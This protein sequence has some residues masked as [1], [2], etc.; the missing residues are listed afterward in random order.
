M[1]LETSPGDSA[2]LLKF[3]KIMFAF[4]AIMFLLV[5]IN[6]GAK[7]KAEVASP[8]S[9]I[10][11]TNGVATVSKDFRTPF[12]GLSVTSELLKK[13]YEVASADGS[14]KELNIDVYLEGLE[15]KYGKPL[16]KIKTGR[17]TFGKEKLEEYRKYYNASKLSDDVTQN[18]SV[19]LQ[20]MDM[21]YGKFLLSM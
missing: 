9:A 8:N 1:K 14:I 5:W 10:T 15:D 18:T 11:V 2:K 13:A 17:I 4:A 16:G 21:D 12:I 6:P 3:A 19:V 7:D 20:L